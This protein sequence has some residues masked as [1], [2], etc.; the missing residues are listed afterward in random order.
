MT[1]MERTIKIGILRETKNPPDRRVPLTPPQII[2]L[3]ELYPFVEFFVQPSDN[4]C[5]S[6][7]EYDYLDI[8]LKED[9]KDCDILLGV[10]E[11]DKRTF[12]P[13]K[14]YLFFAHVAKKQPHN[15]EMFRV[16]SEKKIRLIDYEYLTT[17]KGQRVVAFG[18][19]AGIVGA[20]NG[21]RARGIKT[22]RFKLKPAYQCHDLEEMWAGLRLI[23]F[24]PGIK[25]LVTGE[26]RVAS[27]AMETLS[28]CNI[29]EVTPEEFLT[30]DFD[31]PVVCQIG[32]QHYTRNKKGLPFDFKDFTKNPCDYESAFLPFTKVT[33]IFITGHFWDP[34]SP[35]FFT[36]ENMRSPDFRIS[37]IADISC[38]VNGPIPSTIRV[39]TIADPFYAYNP[40]LETEEPAFSSPSNITVMAVDNLPGELPRDASLDFGKML[41]KSVMYDILTQTESPMIE[42]ATILRDGNLTSAFSYLRDY[43]M[44]DA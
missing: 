2:A 38:D 26:G 14:T 16:M 23:Q 21:L 19:H 41:M 27:G 25:I 35:V 31:I 18:R 29:V 13:G 37:I 12:I 1:I 4:R 39:S 34:Y 5:Y 7:E 24:V 36:S 15:R 11:V 42:R 30:K 22:N 10:K 20:Y 32:P 17:E 28:I 40:R 9:L 3:E 43:P 8:P 33:D 6:D 44:P